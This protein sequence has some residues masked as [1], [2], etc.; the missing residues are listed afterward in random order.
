[1]P[2]NPQSKLP[3]G[4]GFDVYGTLVDPLEM[5]RHLSAHFADRAERLA[6]LWREKQVEYAFRRGLMGRYENF[7]VCTRQALQFALA[8]LGLELSPPHQEQLIEHYQNLRPFRDVLPAIQALRA[9]G[10]KLAAFS[11]GVEATV[12]DLLQSA[13]I[14]SHLDTVISV[15]DLKTFKPDPKV[16][17][18]LAERLGTPPDTTWLVSG[19]AWDVLGAKSAGLRGVWVKRNPNVVLDPWEIQPDLVVANLEQLPQH[20]DTRY[21]SPQS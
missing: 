12:R 1:M 21:H 6:A 14:L 2:A 17:A 13:G 15:D 20:F 19:N 18:Y 11:N 8:T 4:V 7:G 9:R 10:D 5:H 16:Y 3:V